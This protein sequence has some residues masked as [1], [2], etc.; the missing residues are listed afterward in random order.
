MRIERNHCIGVAIDIQEKLFPFISAREALEANLVKLI[1]GLNI[2][3]IPLIITEQYT[4][5][6]G[7]TIKPLLDIFSTYGPIEKQAFSCCDEPRFDELLALSTR[8]QVIIFGIESHVCVLQ[9]A[10]DL[11]ERGFQPILVEDAVSS[12]NLNDKSVAVRRMAREGVLI[13]TVESLLFEL[14]RYSGT[15]EFKEIS[16]LVK[17]RAK[18]TWAN[19]ASFFHPFLVQFLWHRTHPDLPDL[20]TG[21]FL[22]AFQGLPKA[23]LTL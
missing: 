22:A 3:Q 10:I 9:T 13:T 6:L 4:K 1:T 23:N 8:R 14:L 21:H 19:D 16:R 7:Q 12:R 5:G 18:Q 15:Q 17:W 2:L 11:L 20:S